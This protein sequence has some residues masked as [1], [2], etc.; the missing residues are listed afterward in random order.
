VGQEL[1]QDGG[2]E[3][4]DFAYWN[5][6]GSDPGNYNLVDDGYYTGV[7]PHAGT[8]AA[9]LGEVGSLSY[10]SQTLPTRTG[11]PYL[12]SFWFESAVMGSSTPP[13]Q[14]IAQWNGTTLLNDVNVGLFGWTNMRYVVVAAGASTVLQFSTRN[15]ADMFGLD[16]VSV[17]PIPLPTVQS[18]LNSNGA[19]NLTWTTMAGLAYQI[20]YKTNLASTNWINLGGLT[21][22]TSSTMSASDTIS[23][24]SGRFYRIALVP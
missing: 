13:N 23:P 9:A 19:V 7:T 4:G 24:G 8:Y 12:L 20:Q 6:A 11:Q 18:I 2:F 1:V 17:V 14:F 5:L 16:D 10:L 22:A 3:A 15:D 21:N